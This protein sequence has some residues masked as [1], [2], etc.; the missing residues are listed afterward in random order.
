MDEN[1]ISIDKRIK[2]KTKDGNIYHLNKPNNE[3][4][5]KIDLNYRPI[6]FRSGRLLTLEKGKHFQIQIVPIYSGQRRWQSS[7]KVKSISIERD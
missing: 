7:A 1:F 2:I 5:R 4:T 3:M 6:S